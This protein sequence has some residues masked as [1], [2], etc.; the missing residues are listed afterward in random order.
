MTAFTL[1]D[2]VLYGAM[3]LLGFPVWLDTTGTALAAFALEPAA[4]FIVGF[5]HSLILALVNGNAGNLLFYGECA[6]VVLIYGVFLRTWR[7]KLGTFRAA[8]C[9]V[10]VIAVLQSVIS[11]SLTN[12]LAY[13]VITTPFEVAYENYFTGIGMPH[14]CARIIATFIDR[15]LDATAVLALATAM[16]SAARFLH[17]PNAAANMRI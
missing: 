3:S 13:G 2:C 15:V 5:V 17:L 11:L 10:L 16:H 6:V 4:G 9:A 1:L 14:A 12:M 8:I 7:A